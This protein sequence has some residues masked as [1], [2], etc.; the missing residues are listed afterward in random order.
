MA[1]GAAHPG[2]LVKLVAVLLMA[3]TAL[4]VVS[5]PAIAEDD[6]DEKPVCYE[7]A[8][9]YSVRVVCDY[10]GATLGAA[11]AADPS[12]DW[13]I[14]QLCKDGTSGEA[15]ACA[16]PRVC[17]IDGNIGTLYAVFSDGVRRGT[18][19]LTA[20]E[21]GELKPSIRSVVIRAFATLNWSPS[22]MTVQPPGGETLVNLD[23]NFFTTNDSVQTIQVTL[24]GQR[25]EV[26]ARPIAYEWHFGDGTSVTTSDP[27]A[28]YPALDVSHVYDRK[29]KVVVSVDTQYGDAS[30]TVNGGEPEAIASTVWIAG[31]EQGLAIVEA[32]PQLVIR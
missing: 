5:G 28:P 11:Q 9:L 4:F 32:L 13:R 30:F 1:T 19:C 12:A 20:G 27:G 26:S 10:S 16:N 29:D 31:G 7:V 17:T 14:Y 25:V 21:A 8:D 22:V 23:T 24:Q 2:A 3:V 15:E 6:D 18:A